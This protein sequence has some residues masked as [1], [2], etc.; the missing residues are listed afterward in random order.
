MNILRI[1]ERLA[2][3][4]SNCHVLVTES[5]PK[6]LIS[7]YR[8]YLIWIVFIRITARF[9]KVYSESPKVSDYRWFRIVESLYFSGARWWFTTCGTASVIKKKKNQD[10]IDNVHDNIRYRCHDDNKVDGGDWWLPDWRRAVHRNRT[11][12]FS[13]DSGSLNLPPAGLVHLGPRFLFNYFF[14]YYS[15]QILLYVLIDC[16][17]RVPKATIFDRSAFCFREHF[18]SIRRCREWDFLNNWYNLRQ[19]RF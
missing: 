19:L 14:Y 2:D 10:N 7:H 16:N 9:S 6:N 18:G 8:V 13:D 4:T 12:P 3:E 15:T 17:T 5:F 1:A 11:R